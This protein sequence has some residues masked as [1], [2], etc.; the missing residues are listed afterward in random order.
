MSDGFWNV[1]AEKIRKWNG[2]V[3]CVTKKLNEENYFGQNIN[4]SETGYNTFWEENDYDL[5]IMKS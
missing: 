5:T 4:K 3:R 2:L 1:S